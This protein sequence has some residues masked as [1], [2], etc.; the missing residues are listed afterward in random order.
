[1]AHHRLPVDLE[2]HSTLSRRAGDASVVL[3]KNDGL[4]PLNAANVHTI[5]L[6]GADWFAGQAIMQPIL[7]GRLP[8]ARLP[9]PGPPFH[10]RP[11]EPA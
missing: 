8:F 5:A 6:I 3:L 11:E 4:L 2:A 7:S 10:R 1:M 9:D